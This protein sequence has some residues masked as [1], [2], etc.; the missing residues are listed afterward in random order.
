MTQ[1]IDPLSTKNI[2]LSL[3]HLVPEIPGP[4]VVLILYQKCIIYLT[5][6]FCINYLHDF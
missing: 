5:E 6:G 4:T 2:G 3:S 1:L